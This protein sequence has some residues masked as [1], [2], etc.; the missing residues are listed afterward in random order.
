MLGW[1]WIQTIRNNGTGITAY[2]LHC[3][4]V[5]KYHLGWS[6]ITLMKL[7]KNSVRWTLPH[8]TPYAHQSQI[9]SF[10]LSCQL[11][12]L[13]IPVQSQTQHIPLLS[14]S[15]VA[16]ESK[17]SLSSAQ[18]QL[19]SQYTTIEPAPTPPPPPLPDSMPLHLRH[20]RRF[21]PSR[22]QCHHHSLDSRES[23]CLIGKASHIKLLPTINCL[24]TCQSLALNFHTLSLH[25]KVPAMMRTPE[26][27]P[28]I[29]V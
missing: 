24:F 25:H 26:Q 22:F 2:S 13:I 3:C 28:S 17:G 4:R 29:L 23:H 27:I 15:T 19:S 8:I 14:Q 16:S 5:E 12:P 10:C 7:S 20:H 1:W 21:L 18:I 9:R 11:N 6:Q